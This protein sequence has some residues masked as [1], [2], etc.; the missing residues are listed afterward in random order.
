MEIA[1][2]TINGRWTA[3]ALGKVAAA[4]VAEHRDPATGLLKGSRLRAADD[5]KRCIRAADV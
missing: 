3:I 1:W 4:A 2:D 5:P